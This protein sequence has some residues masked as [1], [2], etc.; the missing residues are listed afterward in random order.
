V[1]CFLSNIR[2]YFIFLVEAFNPCHGKEPR[3]KYMS[4]NPRD[5][6]SSRLLCSIPKCVLIDAYL[7]VPVR[8]L[9][10]ISKEE[11]K[12]LEISNERVK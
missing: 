11:A 12:R 4:T 10:L 7:A 8:F 6:M 5:S 1:A 9:P 3:R 2:W